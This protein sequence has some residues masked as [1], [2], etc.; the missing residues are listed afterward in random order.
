MPEVDSSKYDRHFDPVETRRLKRRLYE[1]PGYHN[2]A[3][4]ELR[5]VRD[6]KE[7]MRRAVL[8]KLKKGNAARALYEYVHDAD[9]YKQVTSYAF[10]GTK[11]KPRHFDLLQRVL[12]SRPFASG[13]PTS[14]L[15]YRAINMREMNSSFYD[16]DSED[17][18]LPIFVNRNVSTSITPMA[19]LNF[20]N[21]KNPGPKCCMLVFRIPKGYPYIYMP[22]LFATNLAR[23]ERE[24]FLPSGEYYVEESGF[25]VRVNPA[26]I[27]MQKFS[28]KKTFDMHVMVLT[29]Y[30]RFS[31]FITGPKQTYHIPQTHRERAL[32]D[33]KKKNKG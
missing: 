20:L 15:L 7:H 13:C 12:Y 33:A 1:Y 24:V 16:Y 9:L 26:K 14:M 8:P 6:M 29:P 31:P 23:A 30:K 17:L 21:V 18:N 11:K 4:R 5:A 32:Q 3:P 28:G 10:G 22:A 19:A 27:G 2:M 25:T